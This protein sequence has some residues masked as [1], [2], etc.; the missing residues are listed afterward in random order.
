[1]SDTKKLTPEELQTVKEIRQGYTNLAF[2]LGELELQKSNLEKDKIQLLEKQDELI[3]K[4]KNIAKLLNEKYGE[5]V[6]NTETGEI[7]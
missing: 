6:I 3:A 1:M 5:G 4:E 7:S 2:A